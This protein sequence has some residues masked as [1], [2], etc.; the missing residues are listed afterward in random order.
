MRIKNYLW[1][2]PFIFF[3][4]GYLLLGTLLQPKEFEAPAIVGKQLLNA[5]SILSD[6]KSNIRFLAQ[7][8]D[9][10]LPQGTILSQKPLPGRKIKANQAIYVVISKKPPKIPCPVLLGKHLDAITHELESKN[11][12]NKSYFLPSNCPKHSCIAQHPCPLI[13]LKRNNVITYVSDG[14]KKPVI[15]PNFKG[16]KALNVMEFLKR[17]EPQITTEI[18]H[19]PRCN[20]DHICDEH[21]VVSDQRPLAGSIIHLDDKKPIAVHLKV[22]RNLSCP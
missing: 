17:Y 7:R 14:N 19:S 12:R 1:I 11:I 20:F 21:C 6:H 3:L 2:I 4:F 22:K 13:P 18:I 9:S 5:I 16:K 10:D 8:E 15:L